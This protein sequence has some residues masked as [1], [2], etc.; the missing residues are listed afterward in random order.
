MD[1]AALGSLE[2]ARTQVERVA[3]REFWPIRKTSFAAIGSSDVSVAK[4]FDFIQVDGDEFRVMS[5]SKKYN[6]ES[7]DFT[8]EYG[9]EWLGG[10]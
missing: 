1:Q 2:V 6:A 10:Q 9:V 8:N 7:N 4:I 3:Q 5:V